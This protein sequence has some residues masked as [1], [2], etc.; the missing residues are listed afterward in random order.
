M[1]WQDDARRTIVSEKKDLESF[2]GYWVKV[3]KYSISAKDEIQSVLKKAQ[4][5]IDKKAL[6]SL[7]AKRE[8]ITSPEELQQSV[9]PEELEM[10]VEMQTA[11]IKSYAIIRIRHGVAEHNFCDEGISKETEKFALDI[12]EYGEIVDEILTLIEDFN[13][14]LAAKT[15][16]PSEMSQNGSITEAPLSLAIPSPMVMTPQN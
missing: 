7:M 13:R 12:M 11:E 10:A 15:S 14:P 9:T 5:G 4:K 8:K 16:M 2:P 3:R 6:L 1:G